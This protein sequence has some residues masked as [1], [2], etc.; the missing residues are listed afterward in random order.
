MLFFLTTILP[1]GHDVVRKVRLYIRPCVYGI[2]ACIPAVLYAYTSIVVNLQSPI[3]FYL[4]LCGA[5]F[6]RIYVYKERY[7][8]TVYGYGVLTHNV[9]SNKPYTLSGSTY[10]FVVRTLA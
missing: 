1:I 3:F 7:Q 9:V 4:L 5:R 6:R 8:H 2:G 10:M